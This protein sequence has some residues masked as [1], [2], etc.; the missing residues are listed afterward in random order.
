MFH[1]PGFIDSHSGFR[2]N[3]SEIWISRFVYLENDAIF[4]FR[5][6]SYLRLAVEDDKANV[7]LLSSYFLFLQQVNREIWLIFKKDIIKYDLF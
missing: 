3:V 6:N 1:V 7:V 5:R 4:A 2:C